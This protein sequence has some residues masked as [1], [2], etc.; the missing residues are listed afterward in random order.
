MSGQIDGLLGTDTILSYES[1]IRLSANNH[2]DESR[3]IIRT[4][5]AYI[6]Y[7]SAGLSAAA[8]AT[9]ASRRSARSLY[10]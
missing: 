3:D 7:Y 10:I 8:V 1:C 4:K 2:Y 6:I 5:G 9:S